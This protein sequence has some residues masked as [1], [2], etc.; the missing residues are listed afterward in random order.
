[1]RRTVILAIAVILA[2]F[3]PT[4]I[5]FGLTIQPVKAQQSTEAFTDDFSPFNSRLQ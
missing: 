2:L 4:L 5:N 1:M 3:L